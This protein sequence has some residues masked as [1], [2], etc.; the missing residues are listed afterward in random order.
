MTVRT[1]RA[2][3]DPATERGL[4][5]RIKEAIRLQQDR[6][7]IL[8]GWIQLFVV[9]TFGTLYAVSPKTFAPEM[10]IEP[11]PW[12]LAFYLSFTLLRLVLAHRGRL[13]GWFLALSVVIDIALL[14]SLIWS[15]HIQYAQPPSFV[16]KAPTLLYVFIF[17][18][19]RALRFEAR[20]V[21][22][23]GAAAAIGWLLLVALAVDANVVEAG[24]TRDYVLYMTSNRILLGA[25]FDKVMSIAAVTLVIAVA[26]TRARGLLIRAVAEGAAA[27]DLSRFFAPEIAR[28]I[29]SAEHR[30]AAGQGE[31]RDAAILNLDLRGFTTYAQSVPA[32]EAIALLAEYQSRM[33]PMIQRHGGSIDKFLG[34]G[35]L[36]TFGAAVPSGTYAADSLAAV[37]SIMAEV[38]AWNMERKALGRPPLGVGAS[39]ATGR[40]IFGAVGDVTRLEYTVI[41]DA[42]NLSEKL[43]KHTKDESVRALTT[44]DA[45]ALACIQ[46]YASRQAP[47]TRRARSVGG[48][49]Q[50]IDLVVLAL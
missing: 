35:I 40:I 28:Q 32:T 7:E 4:P 2:L 49:A 50:P 20:Y 47:E 48:V 37:D 6:S 10:G 33:V 8:I 46:G 18:A 16:L 1:L 30:I 19:L 34:D 3:V 39:V 23:T 41:G 24:I 17:I 14:M 29:T 13:P 12:V 25:E 31:L 27:R 38:E 22:L 11:V 5:E 36:A 9:V 21:L 44:T 15:F 42:V 45:Y 26:I 43:E